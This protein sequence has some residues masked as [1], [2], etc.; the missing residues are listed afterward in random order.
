M[1]RDNKLLDLALIAIRDSKNPEN[2]T[3]MDLTIKGYHPESIQYHLKMLLEKGLIEG[4]DASSKDG[5][6]IIPFRLNC[7]GHDYI[8]ERTKPFH[9]KI[10][11]KT[12][13]VSG[14]M[15]L[16]FVGSLIGGA[17]TYVVTFFLEA[18]K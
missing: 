18:C 5:I 9:K 16:L 17:G 3:W 8:D 15:I 11:Q 12:L 13:D 7:A 10:F 2:D 14:K 4:A 1:D 6:Y